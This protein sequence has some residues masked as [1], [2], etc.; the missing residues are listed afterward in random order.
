MNFLLDIGGNRLDTG[1]NLKGDSFRVRPI[2]RRSH[3]LDTLKEE[4]AENVRSYWL[5]L[6]LEL[7]L[8]DV[9]EVF[10]TG[11]SQHLSC[12]LNALTLTRDIEFET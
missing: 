9:R 8:F 12:I 2:L 4:F 3:L 7:Q 10:F 11:I 6:V 1:T 5:Y